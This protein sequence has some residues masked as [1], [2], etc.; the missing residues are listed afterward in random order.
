PGVLGGLAALMEASLL[1]VGEGAGGEPRY[2]MLETV[3]VFAQQQ[4]DGAGELGAVRGRYLRWCL[5]LAEAAEPQ[6]TGPEQAA[7]LARLDVEHDNLRAA[8][9]WL[10]EQG[11]I[12]EEMRLA[13]ALH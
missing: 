11:R 2:R 9:G 5:A 6:L 13:G 8:L 12:E 4:L 10:V 3:R 7:W 1:L